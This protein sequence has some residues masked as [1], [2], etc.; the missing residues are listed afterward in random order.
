MMPMTFTP[1]SSPARLAHKPIAAAL[2]LAALQAHAFQAV[3]NA[4]TLL[5]QQQ[6]VRP[7]A[8]QPNRPALQIDAD[9]T[10]G[11]PASSPFVVRSIRIAGNAAFSSDVLHGLVASAEGTTTTLPQLDQLAARITAWYR[12]HGYPLSRAIVPAQTIADGQVVIQVVEARYGAVRI[13]NSSQVGSPLLSATLAPLQPGQPI[14]GEAL[15]RALL[16]LSDVPGVA[17]DAVIKPGADV[18]TA[19]LDVATRLNPGTF[20]SVVLDNAGNRYIGRTRLGGTVYVTNPLHHGDVF[21]AGIV[22]T[23]NGMAYGRLGY[24][25]LLS[26]QGTR[27]GVSWSRV[28]YA[29][30]GDVDAL[31]AYGTANVSSGWIR[32]PIVRSREVN[33]SGQLEYDGKRLR[34]CIGVT[35]T[36]TDRHLRNWV[37]SLSGDLRDAWLGG[38]VN[39]WSLGWTRGSLRFDD[40]V[41]ALADAATARTRGNFSKWNANA[42]RLQRLGAR[43]AL[44]V[45][46]AVQWANANLDSAEKMTVGGPY[47]VRAYDIGAVSGDTGYIASAELRHEL[48]QA[49]S[50]SLQATAFIDSAR[51]TINHSA[52]VRGE[53]AARLSGVGAGLAWNGPDAWRANVS[54]ATPVGAQPSLLGRQ[55]SARGWVTVSKAF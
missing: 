32:Q 11:L 7:P 36:R 3:P 44:Y 12:D 15:D 5:Q 53:N 28:H 22:S 33:V 49:V 20:A 50:G 17:V 51:V 27:A 37:L 26:G 9:K 18:G 39:A 30:Q 25:A 41:A 54:I 4:G 10:S 2:L 16:L 34:D 42:S 29:L 43:D 21:D 13:D 8:P 52:W 55:A 14:A 40:S 35:D 48:G 47:T 23:G 46:V 45:N 24:E 38:G 6:P 1:S 19:D 31:D